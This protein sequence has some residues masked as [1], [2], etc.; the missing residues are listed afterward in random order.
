MAVVQLLL[1]AVLVQLLLVQLLLVQLLLAQQLLVQWLLLQLLLVHLLQPREL[2]GRVA[3]RLR[4]CQLVGLLLLKRHE[5]V[6]RLLLQVFQEPRLWRRGC[7][8]RRR[9]RTLR[10]GHRLRLRQRA[11]LLLELRLESA[12]L[13]HC[14]SDARA[15]DGH[16]SDT[17]AS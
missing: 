14:V 10:I 2:L 6:L 15:V 5:L 7:W 12:Q 3:L 8:L 9:S 17:Q 11:D 4:L 16:A 13:V 1:V